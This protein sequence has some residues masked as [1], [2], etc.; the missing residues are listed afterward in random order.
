[1]YVYLIF[2][3]KKTH[4]PHNRLCALQA[5]QSL[6]LLHVFTHGLLIFDHSSLD[7]TLNCGRPSNQGVWIRGDSYYVNP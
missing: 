4:L 5:I 1:M 3:L 6:A 2:K 7:W